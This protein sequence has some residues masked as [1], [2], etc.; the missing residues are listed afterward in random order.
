MRCSTTVWVCTVV[1]TDDALFTGKSDQQI[2]DLAVESWAKAG[3]LIESPPWNGVPTAVVARDYIVRSIEKFLPQLEHSLR[4]PRAAVVAFALT[5]L[6][7]A[8]SS[9]L[10][11][12]LLAAMRIRINPAPGAHNPRRS[13]DAA[14]RTRSLPATRRAGSACSRSGDARL[15][16][17]AAG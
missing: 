16:F 12:L 1:E 15:T 3:S 9:L 13:G 10:L 8:G 6:R 4:D 5:A 14:T 17:A 2:F 7:N 11:R